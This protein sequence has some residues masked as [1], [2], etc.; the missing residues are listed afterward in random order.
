MIETYIDKQNVLLNGRQMFDVEITTICN[1]HCYICP[2]E[3]FE[4]INRKM[5][6]ET[7][8]ILCNW[9]PS[10]CDVF[11]AGFGEPLTHEL[12][13]EF[14]QKLHKSGRGT[15]IMT[16]GILLNKN[17][18]SQLFENGLDKLQISI[19]KKLELT[20][21]PHFF[22]LIENKYKSR[23]VF[24]IITDTNDDELP[25][26]V[27]D[28]LQY[29]GYRHYI[30]HI[31]KRAGLLYP[32]DFKY[33]LKT[34]ASFFVDT[35]IDTN[36]LIQVCCNDINGLYNIGSIRNM[37]FDD[38]VEYKR[39]FLGNIQICNLCPNCTDEY[40]IKHFENINKK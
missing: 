10:D 40:R 2:R 26:D 25:I 18:I 22:S 34:C 24:N 3:K 39:Q 11:F 17:L 4:R 1:K 21:L 6:K 19:I 13:I 12:C 32:P 14:I 28:K 36:G 23:I 20:R 31:H 38:L 37:N 33:K 9:L 35:Y 16:N 15:S 27:Q 7:F 8:D 29:G 30:K 5:T